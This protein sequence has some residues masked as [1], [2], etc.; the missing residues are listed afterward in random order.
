MGKL[1]K[2]AQIIVDYIM[3]KLNESKYYER[4]LIEKLYDKVLGERKPPRE[5]RDFVID[6]IT[7]KLG[8][9]YLDGFDERLARIMQIG[10]E[11]EED[12]KEEDK[13]A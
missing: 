6:T 1:S 7:L 8:K 13:E 5:G 2:K 11:E 3:S 12:N 10:K 4:Q 9:Q